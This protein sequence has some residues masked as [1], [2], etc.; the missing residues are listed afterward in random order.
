MAIFDANCKG[1]AGLKKKWQVHAGQSKEIRKVFRTT[2]YCAP[3]AQN[4]PTHSINH[5][6]PYHPLKVDLAAVKHSNS[7]FRGWANH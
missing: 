4:Y 1:E 7:P 3:N 6:V 2:V 5:P